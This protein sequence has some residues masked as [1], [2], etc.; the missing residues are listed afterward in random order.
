MGSYT[1]SEAA[2]VYRRG[3]PTDFL[4]EAFPPALLA[5]S[6]YPIFMRL[7]SV[8]RTDLGVCP[9]CKLADAD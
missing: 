2:K 3:D 8:C 6:L 5:T 9:G 7:G 1:G 4:R